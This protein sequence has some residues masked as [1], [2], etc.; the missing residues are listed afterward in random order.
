[1]EERIPEL[2]DKFSTRHGQK[3]TMGMLLDACDM[4]RTADGM[5]PDVIVNPHCI[6]SR[7]TMAQLLEQLFGKF[8]AWAGAKM[9][10]TPFMNDDQS[11][12][13]IGDALEQLGLQRTGE[14]IMYSGITGKM[15]STSVFIGP[16]HFMRLKHLTQDKMNARAAGRREIRTH[17]PTGGRGNEGGMRI[18]EMERDVLIAHG[19]TGF[20]QE[21]MMKRSDGTH[22]WVCNGCGTIPIVNEQE[23]LFVCPACDGP[24]SYQGVTSDTIG[25]V[26]PVKKSR[27]TFSRVEM[28]YAMKLLDQELTTFMN[29]G[30][31]YLTQGPTRRFREPVAGMAPPPPPSMNEVAENEVAENEVAENEVAENE[32]AENEAEN[33]AMNIMLDAAEKKVISVGN[34]PIQ[35]SVAADVGAEE[36]PAD[37]EDEGQPLKNE[38]TA[39]IV[40]QDGQASIDFDSKQNKEFGT[41]FPSKMEIDGKSWSTVEHYFQAQKFVS[42]PAYQET[43]RVAKTPAQAKRLGKT[44][45]IP[46]RPDWSEV[47]DKIMKNATLVK[48][49]QNEK[50][51]IKLLATG[52]SLLRDISTFDNYWGVGK[53]G[54]GQNKLGQILMEV[55]EEL[56]SIATTSPSPREPAAFPTEANAAAVA[57]NQSIIEIDTEEARGEENEEEYDEN[58][59]VIKL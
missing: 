31:R 51:T 55:R 54:K 5:V 59:K 8:G 33:E 12:Q 21:S 37:R 35:S 23:G 28:P 57:E 49:K 7:M 47:R 29:A 44:S 48:F 26:L 4:P 10:A 14:E 27:C 6:P 34:L 46:I 25:L 18:G 50:L 9:N 39:P 13:A 43:I 42:N 16:L 11:L 52:D 58:V 24:V 22:F 19:T 53:T 2:G 15:F 38:L 32:V 40:P 30:F 17:Q 45:E 36:A 56:K 20:L 3:G 41:Y 1:L